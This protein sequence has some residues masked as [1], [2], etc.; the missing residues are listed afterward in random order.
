M[1]V[2]NSVTPAVPAG[3]FLVWLGEIKHAI[4]DGADSEVPCGTCSACCRSSQFILVADTDAAARSVIP[5]DLLFA[6]PGLA[7]GNHIMG[8]DSRGHCPMF[9]SDGCSIY[10]NR[11]Q[12]CR[13][14]DCR[15][16]AATGIEVAADGHT[17]IAA[18]VQQWQF[19]LDAEGESALVDIR[20]A[21][22]Y[23][24]QNSASLGIGTSATAIAI[25]AITMATQR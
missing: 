20:A 11:P 3:N 19:D 16:F 15:I 8:Y 7:A 4:S 10:S 9:G 2:D 12:A 24:S 1:R 5:A 23:V 21:A 14:Y 6:A 13:A 22:S 25:A 18:R 17:E